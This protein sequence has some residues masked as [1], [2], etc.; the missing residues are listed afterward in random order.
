MTHQN[1]KNFKIVFNGAKINLM[2]V[3]KRIESNTP[4]PAFQTQNLTVLRKSSQI[5]ALF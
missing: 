4:I 5:Y 2:P 3:M 1:Y